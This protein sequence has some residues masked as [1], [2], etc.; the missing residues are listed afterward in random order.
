M[1]NL[2]PNACSI[3]ILQEVTALA[4]MLNLALDRLILHLTSVSRFAKPVICVPEHLKLSTFSKVVPFTSTCIDFH[5][6]F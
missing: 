1:L 3:D 6:D 5:Y 4:I 2:V